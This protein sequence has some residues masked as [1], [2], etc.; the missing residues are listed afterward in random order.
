VATSET[1][2]DDT[3]GDDAVGD[4][5][6]ED[7]E[8]SALEDDNVVADA[9]ELDGE[10]GI[11]R[12]SWTTQRE[13][14]KRGP[15]LTPGGLRPQH[16]QRGGRRGRQR[17]STWNEGGNERRL[18]QLRTRPAASTPSPAGTAASAIT[19]KIKY[20]MTTPYSL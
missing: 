19:N 20:W 10:G 14:T 2:V 3:D 4:G 8:S 11:G 17:P 9:T 13:K 7:E 1:E 6:A 15:R 18:E 12:G 5:A 16:P